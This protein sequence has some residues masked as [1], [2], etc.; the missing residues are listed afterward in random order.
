MSAASKVC[1]NLTSLGKISALL[2]L[3][4]WISFLSVRKTMDAQSNPSYRKRATQSK[5]RKNSRPG[6]L[7]EEIPGVFLALN[8]SRKLGVKFNFLFEFC[9]F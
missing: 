2:L 8:K 3:E 4:D 7:Q 6:L 9:L 5:V 1:H